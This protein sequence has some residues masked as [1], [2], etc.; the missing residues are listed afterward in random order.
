M[1]VLFSLTDQL[2]ISPKIKCVLFV[3]GSTKPN[4]REER[5]MNQETFG[6][7]AAYRPKYRG[8]G[9]FRGRGGYRGGPMRGRG[10]SFGRGIRYS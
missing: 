9:G 1:S 7:A 2:A 5:K 10:G 4:W 8:R 3:S 6:V